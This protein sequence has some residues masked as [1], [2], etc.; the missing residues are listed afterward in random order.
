MAANA[1][2]YI[3]GDG[4]QRPRVLA[5]YLR[6]DSRGG[7]NIAFCD[8]AAQHFPT[9]QEFAGN[10]RH[11]WFDGGQWAVRTVYPQA[12]PLERQIVYP[13]MATLGNEVVFIGL[14]RRTV[15]QDSRNATSTYQFFF[16]QLGLP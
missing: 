8:D 13:A 7:R 16:V 6:F 3:A 5:P 9:Q 4:D 12:A 14:D 15:W 2:G 10:L 11:A 1:A